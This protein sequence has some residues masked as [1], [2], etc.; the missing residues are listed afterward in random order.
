VTD[1]ENEKGAGFLVQ[2]A[3]DVNAQHA[4]RDVG[5]EKEVEVQRRIEAVMQSYPDLP[6]EEWDKFLNVE[7]QKVLAAVAE[8]EKLA[9]K[10]NKRTSQTSQTSTV[11]SAQKVPLLPVADMVAKA[12]SGCKLT[13]AEFMLQRRQIRDQAKLPSSSNGK[14]R[15]GGM[16][17]PDMSGRMGGLSLMRQ[18]PSTSRTGSGSGSNQ[19]G[20][21]Q[22][23]ARSRPDEPLHSSRS[24]QLSQVTP[25]GNVP[26]EQQARMRDAMKQAKQRRTAASEIGPWQLLPSVGGGGSAISPVSAPGAMQGERPGLPSTSRL[27]I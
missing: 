9:E 17:S 18:A 22:N 23:S 21:S 5:F 4:H 27:G 8:E 3:S 20:N 26:V 6:R 1:E 11:A 25:R 10:L 19:G 14:T 7:R 2:K 16:G 13:K 12:R 15:H 24:S